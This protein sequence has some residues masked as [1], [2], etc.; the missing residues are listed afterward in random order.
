MKSYPALKKLVVIRWAQLKLIL[1]KVMS[2]LSFLDILF[3]KPLIDIESI[4]IQQVS[5]TVFVSNRFFYLANHSIKS[6]SAYSQ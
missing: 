4:K 3:R 5:F 2:C 6:S 1:V